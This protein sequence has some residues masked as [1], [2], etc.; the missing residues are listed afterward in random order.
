METSENLEISSQ[1]GLVASLMEFIKCRK[2]FRDDLINVCLGG[3]AVFQ[4]YFRTIPFAVLCSFGI[5]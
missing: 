5:I 3:C 2:Y 4:F 1:R